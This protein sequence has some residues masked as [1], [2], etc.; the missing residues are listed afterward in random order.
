MKATKEE[1]TAAHAVLKRNASKFTAHDYDVL[2][3]FITACQKRL[4]SALA[5]ERDRLKNTVGNAK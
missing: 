3:S 1:A 4:P 2:Y 5:V